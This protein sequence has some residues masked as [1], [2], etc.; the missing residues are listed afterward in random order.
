MDKSA[1]DASSQLGRTGG[2]STSPVN[3]I[4]TEGGNDNE[5]EL[6]Y[7]LGDEELGSEDEQL[8]GDTQAPVQ[9]S[10]KMLLKVIL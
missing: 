9:R 10:T 4:D 2:N 8:E 5:E 1:E 3:I 7:S 6:E